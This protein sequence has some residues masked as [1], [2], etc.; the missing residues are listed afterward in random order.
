M[1]SKK[2]QP[3]SA[4]KKKRKGKKSNK[5]YIALGALGFIS[6]VAWWG[7]RP[8]SGTIEYGICKTFIELRLNYPQTLMTSQIEDFNNALRLHYT[9]IDPYGQ[10]RMDFAQCTFRT[11]PT[12]GQLYLAEVKINRVKLDDKIVNAFNQTMPVFDMYQPDLVLP[13]VEDKLENIHPKEEE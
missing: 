13:R 12:S 10:Y 3:N 8:F 11:N 5:R 1:T 2:D 7:T 9:Y 6:A 4:K